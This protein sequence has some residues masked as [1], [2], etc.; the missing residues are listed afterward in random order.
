MK[1]KIED[2]NKLLLDGKPIT[3][4]ELD[5]KKLEE[6]VDELLKKNCDVELIKENPLAN[7]F[8][9]L[10]EKTNENSDLYKLIT[11]NEQE[12]QNYSIKMGELD[13]TYKK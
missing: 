11:E 12:S 3:L 1:I 2:N 7:F 9:E 6:I 8:G 5:A 13:L 10:K 4:K